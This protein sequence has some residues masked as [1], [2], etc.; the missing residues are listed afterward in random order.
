MSRFYFIKMAIPNAITEGFHELLDPGIPE[1]ELVAP[2]RFRNRLAAL[3]NKI[4]YH[5]RLRRFLDFLPHEFWGRWHVLNSL[6]INDGE[7]TYAVFMP[8][9]DIDRL[10]LPG[11]LQR[12]RAAHPR[13]KYVLLLFDSLDSP[14][15]WHGWNRVREVF[16][17]FD[18]VASFDAGDA[19]RLGIPHFNDP[20]AARQVSHRGRFATDVFF[21][22]HDKGR[23]D[24][25]CAIADR[26][27]ADGI[28]YRILL[29]AAGDEAKAK[30]HGLTV[31]DSRL[32]YAEML[33]QALDAKCLLEVLVDGQHS[34]SLR[35]YEAVVY[36]KLLLS[37]NPG[38]KSLPVF[39]EEYMKCFDQADDIDTG[40]LR[41]TESV[42]Y[43]YQGEFSVR[44]LIE[45]IE[46]GCNAAAAET[47]GRA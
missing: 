41:N 19:E 1:A 17:L 23:L 46:A 30:E 3:A 21:V 16:P 43:H 47:G 32:S 7:P 10:I 25:L 5:K 40:W 26:F 14:L 4:R 9:T 29:A 18:L 39:H 13:L 24:K 20:Y 6:R 8:G 31:L 37:D 45:M 15:Q 36:N 11:L 2:F 28:S 44:R 38:I 22:G 42:D 27:R 33:E 12:M 35:Y 34:S